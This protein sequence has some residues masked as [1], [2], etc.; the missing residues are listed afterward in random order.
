MKF[1]KIVL[2]SL[3]NILVVIILLIISEFTIRI[4]ATRIQPQ[5]TSENLIIEDEYYNST[6]LTPNSEGLSNGKIVTVDKYGCRKN[7]SPVDTSKNSWLFLGDSVTMGIG[8]DN[9]STFS[10]IVQNKVSNI[11]IL[12][13]ST[14]GW[15]V[16]DYKNVLRYFINEKHNNLKIKKVFLLYCLNDLYNSEVGK[17]MPGGSAR[18]FFGDFLRYFRLNSRLYIFLKNLFSD[19]AK[20]YFEYDKQFYNSTNPEFNKALNII[21]GIDSFCIKNKINFIVIIL[22]YE[23]QLRRGDKVDQPQ[24][25]LIDDLEAKSIK[26]YNMLNLFTKIPKNKKL[27]YLY[28]DGIHFSNRGH[29]LAA[30]FIINTIIKQ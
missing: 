11:N 9:D 16:Y 30:D 28:A 29:R 18:E 19:R 25:L 15:S 22:P 5:G 3:Y 8:V 27:L 6:G 20:A 23:Y 4:F 14:I 2:F 24:Q 7:N 12:N 13:P 10:A 1:K 17:E 21:E 26:T